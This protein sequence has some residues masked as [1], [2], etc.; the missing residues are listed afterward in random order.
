MPGSVTFSKH[1][2]L[3]RQVLISSIWTY[4]IRGALWLH[5]I[6]KDTF[7]ESAPQTVSLGNSQQLVLC[8]LL[9]GMQ[10][11]WNHL[12]LEVAE[13]SELFRNASTGCQG[14][15]LGTVTLLCKVEGSLTG[16]QLA[17]LFRC[18]AVP[19]T[20]SVHQNTFSWHNIN[21]EQSF[22]C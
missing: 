12:V 7:H 4:R 20:C 19:L 16:Q 13:I 8:Q 18:G 2:G 1:L 21:T 9:D 11:P 15:A 17:A 14:M 6:V 10:C 22:I 5:T 3:K